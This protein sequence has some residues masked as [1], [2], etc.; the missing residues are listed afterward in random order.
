MR[1]NLGLLIARVIGILVVFYEDTLG[2][3]KCMTAT[4]RA[5]SV[6]LSLLCDF[7]EI[8]QRLRPRSIVIKRLAR[9]ANARVANIERKPELRYL[10]SNQRSIQ[11]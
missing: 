11:D 5:A 2:W 7:V 6:T 9:V 3:R 1:T 8:S 10:Y 4:A